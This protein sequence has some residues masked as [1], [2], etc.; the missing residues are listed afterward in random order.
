MQLIQTIE[1]VDWLSQFHGGDALR[2]KSIINSI[3]LISF[4]D[5]ETGLIGNIEK[6][7]KK[8]R[9]KI[10][11]FPVKK[12][13]TL[14]IDPTKKK[15]DLHGS[16]GRIAHLLTN[17]ER[18]LPRKYITTP[19]IESMRAERI[20]DIVLVDDI[21]GTG[22]RLAYSW[23]DS[24]NIDT[25]S[26]KTIKSWFSYGFIKL[27]CVVYAVH[28]TGITHAV[29]SIIQLAPKNI[30]FSLKLPPRQKWWDESYDDLCIGYGKLTNRSGAS[31]GYG[32]LRSTIVF[33]HGCPNNCPS[34]LWAD[35]R[36]WK[37]LFPNRGIPM[38]LF[39]CFDNFQ[40]NIAIQALFD[41]GKHHL[42]INLLDNFETRYRDKDKYTILV[43]LGL[44]HK[45]VKVS[46]LSMYTTIDNVN[47]NTIIEECLKSGLLH[48]DMHLT[49]LGI[50]IIEKFKCINETKNTQHVDRENIPPLYV[51]SQLF[52]C[53]RKF[54]GFP[55]GKVT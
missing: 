42:A 36:G 29:K 46:N 24:I 15:R 16:E 12:E 3:R 23:I 35:G 32:K 6:I 34:I 52:G 55:D 1:A 10:A 43:V 33:Q 40:N 27:W 49:D 53:Q 20:T 13:R 45:K 47:I 2:A 11:L 41:S 26:Q 50:E 30:L 31:L 22:T 54:S 44:L 19:T 14:S 37:A 21:L 51:P 7:G 38:S 8:T 4:S 18:N 25:T 5:F 28:P 39:V 17:I 9:G 48:E